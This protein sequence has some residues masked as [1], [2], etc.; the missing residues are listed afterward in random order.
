[1][2]REK[3]AFERKPNKQATFAGK[4]RKR[5]QTLTCL[6]SESGFPYIILR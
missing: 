6:D 4:Q 3:A 1:V 5:G 2:H